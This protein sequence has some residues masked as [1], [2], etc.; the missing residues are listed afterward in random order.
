LK[1]GEPLAI[2]SI[3]A[4]TLF[5]STLKVRHAVAPC[6]TVPKSSR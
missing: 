5:A 4:P 2:E 1:A 6:I 3:I